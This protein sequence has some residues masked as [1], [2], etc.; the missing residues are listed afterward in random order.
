[1]RVRARLEIQKPK[2]PLDELGALSLSKRQI[3]RKH[4]TQ[5]GGIELTL[6]LDGV[7]PYQYAPARISVVGRRSAEPVC[8]LVWSSGLG[9]CLELGSWDLPAGDHGRT[10]DV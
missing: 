9:D 7:S 6:R 10:I 3:P 8:A 4:Q 1:M 5:K 2:L